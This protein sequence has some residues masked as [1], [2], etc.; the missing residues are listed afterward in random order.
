MLCPRRRRF[1][2]AHDRAGPTPSGE[3]L[4]HG[5]FQRPAAFVEFEFLRFATDGRHRSVRRRRRVAVCACAA[6]PT[7]NRPRA[8][9]NR[10][11]NRLP[12]PAG[13][14]WAHDAVH[15]LHVGGRARRRAQTAS[16]CQAEA[17]LGIAGVHQRQPAWK[18]ASRSQQKAIVPV[19]WR[20]PSFS[21]KEVVWRRDDCRRSA[22]RSAPSAVN[23]RNA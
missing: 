19:S 13:G 2:D 20:P 1:P 21:G 4:D 6:L 12:I 23:Q 7:R 8:L 15:D 11:A 5:A 18:V 16:L 17:F 14:R 22:R 3:M 9:V 10:A